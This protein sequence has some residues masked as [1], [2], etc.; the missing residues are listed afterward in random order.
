MPKRKS[1]TEVRAINAA[2]AGITR[3]DRRQRHDRI[4]PQSYGQKLDDTGFESNWH[5]FESA[6]GL[7]CRFA[8]AG[9][10]VLFTVDQ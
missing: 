10:D 5:W 9:R 3:D 7:Y 2:L 1:P 4:D 6:H 8:A